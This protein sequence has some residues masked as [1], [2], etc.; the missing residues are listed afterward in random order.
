[1]IK[2]YAILGA[3]LFAGAC[4]TH[5]EDYTQAIQVDGVLTQGGYAI[6]TAPPG[7]RI[8]YKKRSLPVD[9]TGARPIGFGRDAATQ[10]MIVVQLPDGQT[11]RQRI[12][13][14]PRH[15]TIQ[16]INGLKKRYVSPDEKTLAHIR[17][18][19]AKAR[20]ARKLDLPLSGWRQVFVWPASGI[21]SGVYGSQRILNGK[22]R[23]THFGVDIAAP[24]GTPVFA[25]ADGQVTLATPMVLSGNT[26]MI[27]HGRGLRSIF[28]HLSKLTVHKGERV[29]KGQKVGEV[30]ATGRATGPHLHWGMSWFNIRLDPATFM[31]RPTLK[32]GARVKA[33]T[34][35]VV[36]K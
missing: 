3:V 13:L 29:H 22:P 4:A 10:Q 8:H 34:R 12:H 16:R 1:M 28:M 14:T 32:P 27:D 9:K 30:G 21:V 33:K 18:D 20:A 17:T 26:L 7:S 36:E 19:S 6:I 31:G 2:R 25:P 35:V 5:A 24:T 11:V 23:R 15:Y